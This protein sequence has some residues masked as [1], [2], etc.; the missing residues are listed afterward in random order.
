VILGFC[1]SIELASRE[2]GASHGHFEMRWK[3]M[4]YG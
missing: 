3:G 2:D 4:V 1:G